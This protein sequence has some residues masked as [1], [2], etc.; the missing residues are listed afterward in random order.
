VELLKA[1]PSLPDLKKSVALITGATKVL[2]VQLS[3]RK[4]AMEGVVN[5]EF[6]PISP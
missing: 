5:R 2:G 1:E 3:F 6:Q 4:A